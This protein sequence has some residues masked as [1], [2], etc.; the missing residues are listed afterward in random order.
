MKHA[1]GII[2]LGKQV[3]GLFVA[4]GLLWAMPLEGQAQLR[5]KEI[6]KKGT[7][8]VGMLGGYSKAI[9]AL[10]NAESIRVSAFV[11]AIE[12]SRGHLQTMD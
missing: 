1:K 8:E 9:T 5:S 11:Y 10:G 4:M 3:C 7:V 2:L 6:M 12:G